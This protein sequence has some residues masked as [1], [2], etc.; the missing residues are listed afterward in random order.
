MAS[1]SKSVNQQK[2]R[3]FGV[4]NGP[5]R[6]TQSFGLSLKK[7]VEPDRLQVQTS[8]VC[9][10]ENTKLVGSSYQPDAKDARRS[11]SPDSPSILRR[12]NDFVSWNCAKSYL[13]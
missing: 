3:K 13:V 12:G 2:C 7:A 10:A 11:S 5:L 6:A 8:A 4:T 9:D 1:K